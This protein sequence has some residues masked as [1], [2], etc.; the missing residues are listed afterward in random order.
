MVDSKQD[1]DI[2]QCEELKYRLN[3]LLEENKAL[4]KELKSRKSTLSKM[5]YPQLVSDELDRFRAL[6]WMRQCDL[7]IEEAMLNKYAYAGM[8]QSVV[9]QE[10]RVV[11]LKHELKELDEVY[12]FMAQLCLEGRASEV[13]EA[14][15]NGEVRARLLSECRNRKE[16]LEVN[17][18]MESEGEDELISGKGFR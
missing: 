15:R 1:V 9:D 8:F 12:E 6:R 7:E 16:P 5:F 13:F 3:A 10:Q 4:K 18:Y 2:H 14:V 17:A 11:V